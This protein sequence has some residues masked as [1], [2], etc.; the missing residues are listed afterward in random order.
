MPVSLRR[1]FSLV[2][3]LCCPFL[4]C[5]PVQAAER[6]PYRIAVDASYAPLSF[7]QDGRW[8][9]IEVDLLQRAAKLEGFAYELL[10]LDFDV[11]IPRLVSGRLDAAAAGLVI[12]DKRRAIMDF[13]HC[14]LCTVLT[15]VLRCG[16]RGDEL[17]DFRMSVAALKKGTLASQQVEEQADNLKLQL[18]YYDS[19]QD[20]AAAVERGEADFLLEDL[21]AAVHLQL[22]SDG[23]LCVSPVSFSPGECYGLAV[24][25]GKNQELLSMFN[26]ALEKMQ[27]DGSY[28]RIIDRYLKIKVP[29]EVKAPPQP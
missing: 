1:L 18:R 22:V 14:Y 13:S 26:R 12:T 7:E 23:A 2:S 8:Q 28:R 5:L 29:V 11:I 25:R 15:P 3:L 24:A 9:G 4:W 6:A 27:T 21:P 20:C 19:T 16:R 17:S 10:P